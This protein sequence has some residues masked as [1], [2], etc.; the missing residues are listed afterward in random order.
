M[1]GRG[2]PRCVGQRG[3]AGLLVVWAGLL[4][5]ATTAVASLYGG[6]VVARHRAGRVAD[7][8]ALAAARA[9]VL[10]VAQPCAAAATLA[11]AQGARVESCRLLGDGSAL[12]VVAV[13]GPSRGAMLTGLGAVSPARARARAGV[14]P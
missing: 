4:V 12:V 1:T 13:P 3:S 14:P 2:G 6:V 11:L 10:G 9:A 5:L 7:V 8:A